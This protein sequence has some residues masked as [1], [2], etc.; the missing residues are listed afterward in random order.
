MVVVSIIAAATC[1][2]E[3]AGDEFCWRTNYD[4]I[5]MILNR[6]VEKSD[7][8]RHW[9]ASATAIVRV[10]LANGCGHEDVG[11]AHL[12]D[13]DKGEVLQRVKKVCTAVVCWAAVAVVA[14]FVSTAFRKVCSLNQY[15]SQS[16]VYLELTCLCFACLRACLLASTALSH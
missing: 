12:K 6:Q 3:T 11:N 16:F 5:L 9:M 13:R 4:R 8:G 2:E 15:L 14:C 10:A 1:V 7:D